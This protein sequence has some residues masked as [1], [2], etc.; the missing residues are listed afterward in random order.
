MGFRIQDL[1][2]FGDLCP[3]VS[4]LS[5]LIEGMSFT[6]RATRAAV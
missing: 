2:V 4:S 3:N 5:A 1:L 6:G